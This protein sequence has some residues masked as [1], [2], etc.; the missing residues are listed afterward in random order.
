MVQYCQRNEIEKE[1]KARIQSE[2]K[3]LYG[4]IK[5]LGSRSLSKDFKIQVYIILIQLGITN[6]ANTWQL[7]KKNF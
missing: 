5:L 4:P 6:G 3:C 1:I 2:N 7:R